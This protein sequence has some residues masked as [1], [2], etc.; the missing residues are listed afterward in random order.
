KLD[1][2]IIEYGAVIRDFIYN[3]GELVLVGGGFGVFGGPNQVGIILKVIFQD[4]NPK[5][6]EPYPNA[7]EEAAFVFGNATNQAS[8]IKTFKSDI[9]GGIFVAFPLMP[10]FEQLFEQ[11]QR[12][13]VTIA[14]ARKRGGGAIVIPVDT[15]VEE[16][17]PPP[18]NQKKR[19][20]RA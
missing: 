18:D 9:P 16:T 11:L 15:T 3:R 20:K 8:A 7:P 14:V 6:M 2:C 10:T 17:L 4:Y 19:S 5:T 12:G 1:G 13:E